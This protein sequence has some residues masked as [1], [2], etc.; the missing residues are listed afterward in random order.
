M[1]PKG[2]PAYFQQQMQHSVF[3]DVSQSILEIYID[4]IITWADDADSLVANLRRILERLREK[5]ITVNPEKCKLGLSEIEDVGHEI[6]SEG[7]S[8]S[9]E[10]LDRVANFKNQKNSKG[11]IGLASY[12]RN[13]IKDFFL[14]T[15]PSSCIVILEETVLFHPD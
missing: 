6:N 4:D 8:F 7:L 14:I 9:K 1:G 3:P 5:N 15:Q 2:A 11:F 10:K 13:H 12:F